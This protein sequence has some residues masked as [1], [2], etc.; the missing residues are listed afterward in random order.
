MR[1]GL[2]LPPRPRPGEEGYDHPETW[3]CLRRELHEPIMTLLSAHDSFDE[4]LHRDIRQAWV[5]AG[6]VL[7]DGKPLHH[8]I[9][10]YFW[11]AEIDRRPGTFHLEV[12]KTLARHIPVYPDPWR[13]E[14]AVDKYRAHLALKD[15]GVAV[16]DFVLCDVATLSL[17]DLHAH[18]TPLLEEWGG[19]VLK[20]RRGAWG[21]GV[22]LVEDPAMLRDLIGYIRATSGDSP[23]G[24]FLLERY[25]DNDLERWCSVTML[26]GEPMYGYRK[27]QAKI[28]QMGAGKHKIFDADE[29][30]GEV[31][32]AVVE[33][34]HK[35]QVARAS[36]AL[37]CPIIGFDMIWT[38]QGPL[39][40]DENTSPGNYLELYDEV[41]IDPAEAFVHM[42]A[43]TVMSTPGE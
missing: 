20:P 2:C 37:G 3:G 38:E 4:I 34:A 16:P 26:G 41:G 31:D 18:L 11:Y 30:G 12:L 28:A 33:A 21:K 15:A 24:G 7:V 8:E 19:A 36:R 22:M 9:D 29:R 13:W 35:E 5:R 23:D 14:I 10:A 39:V 40:V 6:D 43:S 25:H 1:L 17:V 27:R 42:I 32:L